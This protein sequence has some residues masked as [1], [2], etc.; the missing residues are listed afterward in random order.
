MAEPEN[1]KVVFLEKMREEKVRKAVA[2]ITEIDIE[3]LYLAM[4][5]FKEK[6]KLIRN[7]HEVAR[8][9]WREIKELKALVR[10]YNNLVRSLRT[11]KKIV[12]F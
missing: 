3:A 9:N 4:K 7:K 8:I 11:F 2:E 12:K 10:N 5:L 1:K 6:L